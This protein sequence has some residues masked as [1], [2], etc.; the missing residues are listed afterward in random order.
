[1]VNRDGA[2]EAGTAAVFAMPVRVLTAIET[3]RVSLVRALTST[4]V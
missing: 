3:T 4:R 2:G 1:M